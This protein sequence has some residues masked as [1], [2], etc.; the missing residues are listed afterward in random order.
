MNRA[1]LIEA[2]SHAVIITMGSRGSDSPDH[3]DRA[4]FLDRAGHQSDSISS[5]GCIPLLDNALSRAA[6]H[7]PLF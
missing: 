7:L 4:D 1:G 6:V 3:L 5:S 2:S